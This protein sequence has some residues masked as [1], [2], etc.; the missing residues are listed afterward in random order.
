[1]ADP[2]RLRVLPPSDDPERPPRGPASGSLGTPKPPVFLLPPEAFAALNRISA[3]LVALGAP[4]PE[5]ELVSV[6]RFPAF[7]PGDVVMGPC[8]V[9]GGVIVERKKPEAS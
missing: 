2:R 1:M 8:P 5:T 7:Q 3:G 9:T 6:P 4:R